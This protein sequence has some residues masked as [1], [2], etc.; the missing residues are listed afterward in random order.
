M[1]PELAKEFRNENLKLKEEVLSETYRIQG[2]LNDAEDLNDYRDIVK[3]QNKMIDDTIKGFVEID[4]NLSERQVKET[5]KLSQGTKVMKRELANMIEQ[6]GGRAEELQQ[7]QEELEE[8][9][10]DIAMLEG[11]LKQ[12]REQK[13]LGVLG[14]LGMEAL[15]NVREKIAQKEKKKIEKEKT[16]LE[17]EKTKLETKLDKHYTRY[18]D[19][20]EQKLEEH[21]DR[22][23]ESAKKTMKKEMEKIEK[24]NIELTERQ[25]RLV[26]GMR[27][28]QGIARQQQ[29]TGTLQGLREGILLG[30]KD[31]IIKEKFEEE[32]Q[33]MEDLIELRT[34]T[35]GDILEL[36]G[37]NTE[38]KLK[39]Q[40]SIE[41]E[42]KLKQRLQE[43]EDN[44]DIDAELELQRVLSGEGSFEPERVEIERL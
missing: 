11:E 39:L 44:I 40:K 1:S 31:K 2:L 18:Y 26:K 7:T 24:Q 6:I 38:I 35:D 29:T 23:V 4:N 14:V 33:L 30:V 28:L 8:T 37:E 43:L 5:E 27:D 25:G 34:K 3:K 12:E 9:K 36:I 15:G 19:R 13:Q 20:L 42:Q 41:N 22:G 21:F 17:K 16:K 10:F 32:E